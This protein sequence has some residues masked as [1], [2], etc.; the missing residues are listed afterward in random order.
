MRLEGKKSPDGADHL[1]DRHRIFRP[2]QLRTET[3]LTEMKLW[4]RPSNPKSIPGRCRYPRRPLFGSSAAHFYWTT[5]GR[6]ARLATAS[7]DWLVVVVVASDSS[8]RLG[9]RPSI[10]SVEIL[11]P[12]TR[13]AA[14]GCVLCLGQKT[15]VDSV[16]IRARNT[17]VNDAHV[18]D[19]GRCHCLPAV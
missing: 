1:S 6:F 12:E 2:D 15:S 3:C 8:H 14:T 11:R 4:C 17:T 10:P 18:T 19:S 13:K 5:L 16:V 9:P 7:I